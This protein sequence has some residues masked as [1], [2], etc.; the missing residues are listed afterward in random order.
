MLAR[1]PGGVEVV[2]DESDEVAAGEVVWRWGQ[3]GAR[4][5]AEGLVAGRRG[6]GFEGLDFGRGG[7]DGAGGH[8]QQRGEGGAGADDDPPG[9]VHAVAAGQGAEAE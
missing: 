1:Q 8:D 3:Q 2:A 7:V 4:A 6:Q 9:Q 5:V